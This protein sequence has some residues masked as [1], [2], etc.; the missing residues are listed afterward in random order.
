MINM[1][2]MGSERVKR[3]RQIHPEKYKEYLLRWRK[4]NRKNISDWYIRQRIRSTWSE[5]KGRE[6]D[7]ELIEFVRQIISLKRKLREV[8]NGGTRS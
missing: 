6:I 2:M 4:E 8:S 7:K 1:A 3:W 5:F